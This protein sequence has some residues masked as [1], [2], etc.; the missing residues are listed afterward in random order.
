LQ[1]VAALVTTAEVFIA[2]VLVASVGA[3]GL[4]ASLSFTVGLAYLALLGLIAVTVA[5]KRV[6][7]D[8]ALV[9]IL[10]LGLVALP[11]VIAAMAM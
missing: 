7:V 4:Q 6:P 2:I 11:V 3:I 9:E 1:F 10:E 8:R 5:T